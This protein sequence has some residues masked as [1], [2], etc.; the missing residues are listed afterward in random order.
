[1]ARL[2]LLRKGLAEPQPSSTHDQNALKQIQIS[3]TLGIPTTTVDG[4]T[5]KVAESA[6]IIAGGLATMQEVA[7]TPANL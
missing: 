3:T 2:P 1:L 4:T 5:F 7:V 6:R